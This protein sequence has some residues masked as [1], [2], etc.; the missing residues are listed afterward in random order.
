[1]ERPDLLDHSALQRRVGELASRLGVS[2]F[3]IRRD[4]GGEG[5]HV[6]I[7]D[8]YHLILSERGK[9]LRHRTTTDI[10]ELLYWIFESL[11]SI[12]AWDYEVRHRREGEDF[13]RQGFAKHIE[14]I[15]ILSAT[16]ADRLREELDEVLRRHPFDDAD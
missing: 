4:S 13:R 10:D 2:D 15:G 9:E 11:T 7:S 5:S 12:M 3:T 6:E 8:A 14:L 16:W 1:V